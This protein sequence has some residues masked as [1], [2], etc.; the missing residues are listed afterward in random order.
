MQ[1]FSVDLGYGVC[2]WINRPGARL[3]KPDIRR[4][5]RTHGFKACLGGARRWPK[6]KVLFL[7]A[8]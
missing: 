6:V 5:Q 8:A 1:R 3:L 2:V 7:G 4:W